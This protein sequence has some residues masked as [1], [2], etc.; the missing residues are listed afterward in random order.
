MELLLSIPT[1]TY[2]EKAVEGIIARPWYA[3][4]N[5]PFILL[6]IVIILKNRKSKLA[7]MFGSSSILIGIFSFIYDAS[8]TYL[9]QYFDWLGMF[10]FVLLLFLLNLR[11]IT[12]ISTSF[13]INLG[14]IILVIYL[15]LSFITQQGTL[16]FGL[17]VFSVIVTE[18]YLVHKDSTGISMLWLSAVVLFIIGFIARNLDLYGII[19]D[20]SNILNGRGLLHYLATISI[21]FLYLHYRNLAGKYK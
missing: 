4:S 1:V 20:P 10:I 5:I 8:F 18:L 16:F 2:C 9:S 13:V 7:W 17:G 3:I 19:C 14:V 11:R 15:I 12:N 21:L 6:G